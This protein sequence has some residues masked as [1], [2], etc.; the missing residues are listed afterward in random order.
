MKTLFLFSNTEQN[1]SSSEVISSANPLVP[2]LY[3]KVDVS[4]VHECATLPPA[5]ALVLQHSTRRAN[6][7][8]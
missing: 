5:F 3:Y 7:E 8:L 2:A 6:T 1:S 4:D